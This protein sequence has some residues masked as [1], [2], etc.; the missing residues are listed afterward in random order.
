MN[1]WTGPQLH[2][3]EDSLPSILP[4]SNLV[5]WD[6]EAFTTYDCMRL[7]RD[8]YIAPQGQV[9]IVTI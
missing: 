2:E 5:A 6:T 8:L 1:F 7:P 4:I 9:G 3:A